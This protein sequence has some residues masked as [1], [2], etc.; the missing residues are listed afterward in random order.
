M[1]EGKLIFVVVD[2]AG[3]GF[4]SAQRKNNAVYTLLKIAT[5]ALSGREVGPEDEV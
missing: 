3:V 5:S 1:N 2:D 4:D